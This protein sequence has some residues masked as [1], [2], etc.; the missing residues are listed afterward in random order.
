MMR[1]VKHPLLQRNMTYW[2]SA[3]FLTAGCTD[4]AVRTRRLATV[5]TNLRIVHRNSAI[6]AFQGMVINVPVYIR[7]VLDLLVVG[8][9]VLAPVGENRRRYAYREQYKNERTKN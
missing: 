2:K 3:V 4:R 5:T 1:L 6:S 8:I 9:L 7:H